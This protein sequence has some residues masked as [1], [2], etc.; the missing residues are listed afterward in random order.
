MRRMGLRAE[1]VIS[2]R[3]HL[4]AGAN[5]VFDQVSQLAAGEVHVPLRDGSS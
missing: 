2:A 3:F 4:F 5:F 1:N